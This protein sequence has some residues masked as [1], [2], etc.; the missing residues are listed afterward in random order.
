M[1]PGIVSSNLASDRI[2]SIASVGHSGSSVFMIAARADTAGI[3]TRIML[4]DIDGVIGI[5]IR[6]LV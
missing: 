5:F 3:D 1:F 2:R 6:A 4:A